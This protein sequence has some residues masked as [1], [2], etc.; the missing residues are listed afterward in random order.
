M[1][2]EQWTTEDVKV[3]VVVY[4]YSITRKIL[5]SSA[6]ILNLLEVVPSTKTWHVASDHPIVIGY[7]LNS[8]PVIICNRYK[9]ELRLLDYVQRINY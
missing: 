4:V 8:F 7:H 3:V 9:E 5:G 2:L 1:S 6:R